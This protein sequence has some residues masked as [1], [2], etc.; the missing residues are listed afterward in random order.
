[1]TIGSSRTSERYAGDGVS[2]AFPIPFRFGAARDI[3]VA[4]V[5]PVTGI[6]TPLAQAN[7]DFTVTV[8]S[9]GGTLNMAL[10]PAT[11]LALH[12]RR[13]TVIDQQ[14]V[15]VP[16][17]PFPAKTHE[18]GLD[19][20]TMIA[21]ELLD[22]L[23]E[24]ASRSF[25]LPPGDAAINIPPRST[26][27][28]KILALD[29]GGNLYGAT[30]GLGSDPGLR[31]DLAQPT[32]LA[33]A[34]FRAAIVGAVSYDALSKLRQRVDLMD[35]IPV[36][37]HPAIYAGTSTYDATADLQKAI[38]SAREV[39][40]PAGVVRV[41][42]NPGVKL[43]NGTKLIGKGSSLS[44]LLALPGGGT[45]AELR[46]H[47]KGSIL[48][49]AWAAGSAQVRVHDIYLAD[50]TVVTTHPTNAV[51]STAMQIALDLRHIS[52]GTIERCQFGFN[53]PIN[54]II[55]R[56]S[57]GGY[58]SQGYGVVFGT[59]S[60]S[61]IAYCGGEVHALRGCRVY[62]NY[63][64]VVLDD[65]DLSDP[66]S[67]SS[68]HG[69]LVV[70]CDIQGA[71]HLLTQQSQYTAGTLFIDNVVQNTVPQTGNANPVFMYRMAGYNGR[72]RDRYL[73]N[74]TSADYLVYL[75]GTALAND[76]EFLNLSASGGSNGIVDTGTRNRL[77]YR[78][79]TG[80]APGYNSF[81][82]EV[83]LY[84]RAYESAW[85]KCHWTG[86]AMVV[87]G[88]QGIAV[89]RNGA[90]DY[91]FTFDRPMSSANYSIEVTLDTNASGHAG[92]YSVGSHAA[93]NVRLY[94]YALPATGAVAVDPRFIWLRVKQ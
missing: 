24:Y 25:M 69:V 88:G 39:W 15:Y 41:N 28:G 19:K 4:I 33:L 47:T 10:A 72:I 81:G 80:A 87:D 58:E 43:R 3:A 77:K 18:G 91:L 75:D 1:M 32:G 35:V 54:S 55:N 21:Q 86:A 89:A 34:G 14:I 38:D 82:R 16:N 85:I 46:A 60:A 5:D 90:G 49:R 78:E 42:A 2:K 45:I 93:S 70:D 94:T 6:E 13:S 63:K 66:L 64:G 59:V 71:H 56:G 57:Y 22:A 26:L 37:E 11:G 36:A 53:V 61:D 44:I 29:A 30:T 50:F 84:D 17:D 79:K 67:P 65:P 20:L 40:L 51:T 74:G 76:C 8:G 52:R 9:D 68:A 73:E 31:T 12:V 92:G 62:G 83:V 48:G 27:L 23:D 7:G